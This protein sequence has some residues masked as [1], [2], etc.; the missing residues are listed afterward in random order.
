MGGG[1]DS[2]QS[3]KINLNRAD[4]WLL[5]ALPDIGQTR[6]QAIV[7]YRQKNGPFRSTNELLKVEGIGTAIYD[8]I[9]DLITVD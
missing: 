9:K 4:A 7:N 3:Q 1:Q 6:A 5:A 2:P 8:K